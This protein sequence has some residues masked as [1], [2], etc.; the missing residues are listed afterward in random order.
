MAAKF[1]AELEIQQRATALLA[2][3]A[4]TARSVGG[5]IASTVS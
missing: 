4:A 3:A 1:R 2:C 5:A